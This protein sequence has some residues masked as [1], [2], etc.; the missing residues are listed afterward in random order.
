MLG[1]TYGK[2]ALGMMV[3]GVLASNVALGD[4]AVDSSGNLGVGTET[5]NNS[6]VH[7]L[8]GDNTARLRVEETSTSTVQRLFE[9]VHA[10]FPQFN[11]SD[12]STGD[13][14]AFRLSGRNGSAFEATKIGTGGAE[15]FVDENGDGE[16]RGAVT[17][18]AFNTVSSR[19]AKQSFTPVDNSSVLSTLAS[20]P[21]S[22]WQYKTQGSEGPRHIGPMAEDFHAAFG[23][24]KDD[25]HI[26]PTDM[27]GVALASAQELNRQNQELIDEN[28]NLAK[29]NKE[30][31]NRMAS[32]E[33]EL[34][35]LKKMISDLSEQGN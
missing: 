33:A 19:D 20:I 10:G 23:F 2:V 8:R 4:V 22:T 12:T 21:L 17:A 24:G 18:T 1:F 16:F 26:S 29:E 15:F 25:R 14:W 27:A 34:D 7:I 11:F 5:P 35:E 31:S 30:L 32:V 28:Q 9:L 6:S 13:Q 3:A